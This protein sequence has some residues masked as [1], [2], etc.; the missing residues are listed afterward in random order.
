M[1]ATNIMQ[2]VLQHHQSF[3][4]FCIA[5]PSEAMVGKAAAATHQVSW[6]DK[7]ASQNV[8]SMCNVQD[9]MNAYYAS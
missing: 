6:A 3:G 5:S 2:G 4:H 9:A 7:L 8:I 1:Y